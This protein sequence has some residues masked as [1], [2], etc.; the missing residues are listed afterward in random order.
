MLFTRMYHINKTCDCVW[1]YGQC[2]LQSSVTTS[3]FIYH[4]IQDQGHMSRKEITI[5]QMP[6]V[7]MFHQIC[8]LLRRVTCQKCLWTDV[9]RVKKKHCENSHFPQFICPYN[10]R[11]V[12]AFKYR[13]KCCRV[14]LSLKFQYHF[15]ESA[16]KFLQYAH[17]CLI[18]GAHIDDYKE[19]YLAGFDAIYFDSSS[20]VFWGNLFSPTSESKSKPSKQA[21]IW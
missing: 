3:S 7:V 11:Y 15:L 19:Y 17:G 21:E 14:L 20:P 16:N 5:N 13:L 2:S 6:I 8:L 18:W 12:K 9:L 10:V 1:F 4:Q